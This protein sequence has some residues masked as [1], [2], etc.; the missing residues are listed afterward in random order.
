MKENLKKTPEFQTINS[1]L[2]EA[3]DQMDISEVERQLEKLSEV[4]PLPYAIEDSKIFAKRIIKQNKKGQGCMRKNIKKSGIV[5]ACLML[6]IGVT[7]VYG[8]GI[9]KNFKFYNQ[10]T[11]V[12]IRSNQD[13]SEE[14]A[15]RLAKEA[16]KD[17]D[18][19]STQGTTEEAELRTFSS[20][21]EVEETIGI[22]VI[23]PLYIPKDFQMEK[24]IMVQNSFNNNHNIYISYKSNAKNNRSL[25]VTIATQD[26]PEDSTVVTVTDAVRKGQYTTPYGTKYTIL[27]E[28]EGII[29]TTDINNISYNLIFTGV[30][31]EEM[32]RVINSADLRGYIK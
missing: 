1:K 31:K 14:E 18:S 16:E 32:H 26:Q 20:I 25:D 29:A 15:N 23:L 13:I 24:D 17:Y 11:T 4:K 3:I 28:E 10:K 2:D 5:A 9:F 6:T 21:K 12:E 27:K 30:N 8:T 7:A 22:K 19:P